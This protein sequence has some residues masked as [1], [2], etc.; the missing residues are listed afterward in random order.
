MNPALTVSSS[1]HIHGQE[2]TRSLMRDVLIALAPALAAAIVLFGWRSALLTAVC[3]VSCVVWEYLFRRL[4]KRS[5]TIG[6]LSA[7]VTGVLLA[8]NLPVTMPLYMGVIGSAVAIVVVKEFFGGL[9]KNIANPALVGRIVLLVS[10]PMHMTNFTA[11]LVTGPEFVTTATPAH[12]LDFVATAT[13]LA[14]WGTDAQPTLMQLLLGVHAGCL[15]ET[16]ALALL[17][18]GIY[19]L[20]RKVIT[21]HIPVFY[22]GTVALC[23]LIGGQDPL[24]AVLTGGLMLGAF[25]MATDY[26]NSPLTAGGKIAFGVGCGVLTYVIRTFSALPE[27]VSYAILIM[28]LLNPTIERLF[29]VRALGDKS[30]G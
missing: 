25:F 28:N 29:K 6:D 5:K 18:G 13:P 21:W 2:A 24:Y 14:Q 16:C 8:F 26:V 20:A 27:G 11:P 15:G 3:A 9:G 19:M 22:I 30:H 7:V 1:P 17:L 4:L 23:S 10:F 12:A